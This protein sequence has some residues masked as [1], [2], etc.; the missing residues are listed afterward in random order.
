LVKQFRIYKKPHLRASNLELGG[1]AVLLDLDGLSILSVNIEVKQKISI[2]EKNTAAIS[3]SKLT[4][5]PWP[6]NHGY[7]QFALAASHT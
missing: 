1:G 4:V 5:W 2:P 7:Q 3:S 6:R